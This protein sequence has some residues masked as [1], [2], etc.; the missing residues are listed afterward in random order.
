[1]THVLTS[2]RDTR[3]IRHARSDRR[4]FED[5]ERSRAAHGEA[6][7]RDSIKQ[8]NNALPPWRSCTYVYACASYP[9][10][11]FQTKEVCIALWRNRTLFS[12]CTNR[13]LTSILLTRIRIPSIEHLTRVQQRRITVGR[14]SISL[15]GSPS[16]FLKRPVTECCLPFVIG[17]WVGCERWLSGETG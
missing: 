16:R 8:G 7:P 11:H 5:L 17:G 6:E 15:I 3:G 12:T 14:N 2:G 10:E 13:Y 9:K 4:N 1:M